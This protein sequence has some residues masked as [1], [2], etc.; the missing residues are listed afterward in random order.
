MRFCQ[1]FVTDLSQGTNHPHGR[2]S[3]DAKRVRRTEF[4]A[5]AR[6][7]MVSADVALPCAARDELGVTDAMLPKGVA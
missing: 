7:W 6:P 2:F 4:I 3:D 1:A 5:G